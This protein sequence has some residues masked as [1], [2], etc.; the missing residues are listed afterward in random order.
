MRLRW[1]TVAVLGVAAAADA[2]TWT[3]ASGATVEADL[4]SCQGGQVMLRKADGSSLRIGLNLLSKEDQEFIAR[5]GAG[6]AVAAAGT[7]PA[8]AVSAAPVLPTGPSRA[9]PQE[10]LSDADLAKLKNE[11]SDAKKGETVRLNA[12]CGV[13]WETPKQR[14]KWKEGDKIPLR[15]TC[16]LIR[17]EKAKNGKVT[18]ESLL[19]GSAKFY[20]L[21]EAGQP[22]LSKTKSMDSMCP[23]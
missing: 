9:R 18:S 16:T 23:T 4:V 20:L 3:S 11:F 17:Q 6:P 19:T 21:D 2:R 14:E 10:I 8:P 1:W 5:Q 12:S 22:A 13:N 7:A 15:I